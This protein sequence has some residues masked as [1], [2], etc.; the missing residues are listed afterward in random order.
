MPLHEIL[1]FADW[2]AERSI[3]Y[4][5]NRPT[6]SEEHAA[7]IAASNYTFGFC[8]PVGVDPQ[9][10]IVT[11]RRVPATRILGL[12]EVPVTIP[13]PLNAIVRRGA[14]SIEVQSCRA[15]N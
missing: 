13:G 3:P 2:A 14:V 15:Q 6:G 12:A 1:K 10:V 11:H 5:S 9:G 7:Q 8:H 4:V